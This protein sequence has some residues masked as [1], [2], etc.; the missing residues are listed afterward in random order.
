MVYNLRAVRELIKALTLDELK[1]LILDDFPDVNE[2]F[3]EGQTKSHQIRILVSYADKHRE[4]N[5]L[6]EGI[7]SINPTVYAENESKLGQDDNQPPQTNTQVT[8]IVQPPVQKWY[9][10]NMMG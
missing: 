4:I 6:L 9:P 5:K 10:L 1:E 8:T 7:K 3:T 2:Q